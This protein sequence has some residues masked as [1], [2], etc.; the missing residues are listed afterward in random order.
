MIFLPFLV[1]DLVVASILMGMGMMMVPPADRLVALQTCLLRRRRWLDAAGGRLGTRIWDMN[2]QLVAEKTEIAGL[3]LQEPPQANLPVQIGQQTAL[4]TTKKILDLN[5]VEKAA[6]IMIALGPEAASALL[7]EMGEQRIRRF[8]QV[9]NRMDR[10]SADVVEDVIGEFLEL[11]SDKLSLTGGPDEVKRFLGEVLDND[12]VTRIMDDLGGTGTSVWTR[13]GQVDEARLAAWLKLEHPQVSALVL[14]KLNSVKAARV[15]ER[16]DT[17]MAQIVV[18]RMSRIPVLDAPTLEA[19]TGVIE[20]DFLPT[21]QREKG[22]RKPADLIAG[23]MNHISGSVR[24]ELLD[25]MKQEAPALTE[26][27]QKVMFTFNDIVERVS[28]RD[29]GGVCKGVD[30]V[31]LMTAL[32]MGEAMASPSVEFILGNISKRLA[33]RMREDLQTMPEPKKR[34]GEAAQ[35]EL[36]G[37]I[38]TMVDTGQIRLNEPEGE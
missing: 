3:N 25:R 22:N 6:I 14:T 26:E 31:V 27:V 34:D 23:L 24:D 29:V 5:S 20:R 36:I 19:L 18:L 8:A 38:K 32:K 1:I 35:A 10:I 2:E 15:L 12:S 13:L 17:D 28:P 7:G 33:E 4:A 37:A 30:E 11:L 21:V 16:F 9:V